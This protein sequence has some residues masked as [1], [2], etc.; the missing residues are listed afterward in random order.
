VFGGRWIW[1]GLRWVLGLCFPLVSPIFRFRLGRLVIINNLHDVFPSSLWNLFH[2]W[3]LRSWGHNLSNLHLHILR[4]L[5]LT[6]NCRNRLRLRI[7][8]ALSLH[9][10]LQWSLHDILSLFHLPSFRRHHLHFWSFPIGAWRLSL[11]WLHWLH[12]RLL[13][14]FLGHGADSF[15]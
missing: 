12:S 9:W 2:F 15:G 14:S 8:L 13:C 6:R 1:G 10:S 7:L 11:H 3:S 5:G 4:F